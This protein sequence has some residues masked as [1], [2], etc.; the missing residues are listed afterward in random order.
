VM[1]S[2][3]PA[4]PTTFDVVSDLE[5]EM[6]RVFDAPR[7]LVF[8]VCTQPRHM[9]QW[10]GPRKYDLP[11][12]EMDT[13]PG[14]KYRFVQRAEDGGEHVFTGEFLEVDPPQLLVM[15]QVYAPYPD[16]PMLVTLNFED[17]GDGRTRLVDRMRFD[18]I[19]SRDANIAAGME[20]GARESYDRLAELLE[21]LQHGK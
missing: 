2:S 9:A 11:V 7:E 21:T 8:E 13:R 14:G 5:V 1:T 3:K 19:E 17:L 15:T 6:T 18:T 12:C 20:W 16:H 4:N 10:W